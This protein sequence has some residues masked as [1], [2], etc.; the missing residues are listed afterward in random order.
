MGVRLCFGL[1]VSATVRK[2]VG[3]GFREKVKTREEK[4]K[5]ADCMSVW[6]NEKE[7]TMRCVIIV[8]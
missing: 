1:A 7:E 8:K 6:W 4:R 5:K 2:G 3:E